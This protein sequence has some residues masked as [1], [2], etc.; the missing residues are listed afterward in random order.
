ML[1]LVIE[2]LIYA[3][4]PAQMKRMMLMLLAMPVERI[5]SFALG[6]M[7]VGAIG[8]WFYLKV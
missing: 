5:R 3:L 4:F 2:G 6:I 8:C 1:M 7:A